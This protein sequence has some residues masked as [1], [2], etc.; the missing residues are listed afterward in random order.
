MRGETTAGEGGEGV[1]QERD[2]EEAYKVVHV[3]AAILG[4]I[5]RN[6]Q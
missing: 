1:R 2:V 6:K 5:G 3:T 4:S